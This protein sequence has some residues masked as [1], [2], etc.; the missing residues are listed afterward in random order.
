MIKD[1]PKC[2]RKKVIM[3][4]GAMIVTCPE[5]KGV[6]HVKVDNVDAK[7]DKDRD[8]NDLSTRT[9]RPYRRKKIIDECTE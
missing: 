9:K 6:G 4:M 5:C 1:C 3:G 2:K 8:S 7:V